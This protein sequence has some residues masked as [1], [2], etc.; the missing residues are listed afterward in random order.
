M[1]LSN[2][3]IAVIAWMAVF[4]IW[5]LTR[6]NIRRTVQNTAL[7]FLTPVAVVPTCLV[8]LWVVAEIA[9]G[10]RV[11]LWRVSLTKDTIVWFLTSATLICWHSNRTTKDYHFFRRMVLTA[12]GVPV[13]LEVLGDLYVLPLWGELLLIPFAALLGGMSVV[14]GMNPEHAQVKRLVDGLIPLTGLVVFVTAVSQL[15]WNW[16]SV[17]AA[18][19]GRQFLLP[20]WLTIGLL[21][22]VYALGL[23]TGYDAAFRRIGW[24]VEKQGRHASHSLRAKCVLVWTFKTRAHDLNQFTGSWQLQLADTSSWSEARHLVQR[25]EQARAIGVRHPWEEALDL[26]EPPPAPGEDLKARMTSDS[27]VLGIAV[28]DDALAI[29]DSIS[30][31]YLTHVGTIQEATGLYLWWMDAQDWVYEPDCS[32]TDPFAGLTKELGY[33]T[34]MVWHRRS[35]PTVVAAVTIGNATNTVDDPDVMIYVLE[36]DDE[37]AVP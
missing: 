16:R 35:D 8:S 25:Y 32:T 21:P 3:D 11:G 6:R 20:V 18:S 34:S 24:H 26:D 15:V 28:P 14:A 29:E 5:A 33:C 9:L 37:P 2:R 4:G 10:H 13:L 17:N 30:T 23:F 27:G 36:L 19:L 12:I 22:L 1:M 7:C 31:K